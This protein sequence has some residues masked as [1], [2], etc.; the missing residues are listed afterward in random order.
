MPVLIFANKQDLDDC[1]TVEKVVEGLE[2]NNI[3]GRSWLIQS[4]SALNGT[5]VNEGIEWLI[6]IISKN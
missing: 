6:E 1:L 5:G 3:T 4:C 2:L